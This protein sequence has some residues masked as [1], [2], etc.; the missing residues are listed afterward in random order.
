M[1]Y[2][3]IL[4]ADDAKET[5][6]YIALQLKMEPSIHAEV[7]FA[8]ARDEAID[9]LTQNSP[10]DLILVDLWMPDA[11]G[12]L[13]KEAGLKILKHYKDLQAA[14]KRS[15]TCGQAI[16]ITANSSSETVLKAWGLGIHDYISKPIDYTRL[17]EIIKSALSQ[18]LHQDS[19]ISPP[20]TDEEVDYEI[21]GK[22][23]V[24]IEMMKKVGRIAASGSDVLIYGESG[25]GK[26]LVARAIHEYSHRS[27]GPFIPYNCSA[28]PSELIEAELFGIGKR[29]ATAVDQRPGI[30]LQAR[31]GTLLLD[32]IGDL[33]LE[34]QP[35][36]LR[37]LDYKEIQGVGLNVRRVDVRV[38]AATN[39]DLQA[40][41]EAGEFRRDLYYRLKFMI[42][43]PLLR[44]REEDI[45]LLAEHFFHK[46]A[47]TP[48]QKHINGFDRASLEAFQRYHWPGNVRELEKAVELAVVTCADHQITEK[49][50]PP[51]LFSQ[52][53][54]VKL[55]MA[56]SHPL[57]F[58]G[59][60]LLNVEKIKEATQR[61][62]RIFLESK[63]KQNNWN[64]QKTAQQIGMNRKSLHRKLKQ[65]GLQ[66]TLS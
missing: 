45:P 26:E 41:V 14:A 30:F 53:P 3:R 44:E 27:N 18:R 56:D 4:I 39:R 2:A 21:I 54:S 36:L 33:S 34:M 5:C 23:H 61:F 35:K 40:A 66:R 60:N 50:L 55:P 64:V 65:L 24:M 19:A 29:V 22:S 15:S 31:G 63:L 12:V 32:E 57:E 8:Y 9:L 48:E 11:Q 7:D 20:S 28:V 59:E 38:I 1:E 51:E 62:E 17:I 46:Y 43:L 16:V 10:Y 42:T 47:R 58:K 49:D 6:K 52:S 37:V 25:T 13:D